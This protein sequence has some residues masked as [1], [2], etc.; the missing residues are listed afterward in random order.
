MV[1][2]RRV[3]GAPSATCSQHSLREAVGICVVC[4]NAM[5][6]DCITKFDG[7]NH[8]RA[9]IERIVKSAAVVKVPDRERIPGWVLGGVA[10]GLLTVLSYF[11]LEALLPG[12]GTP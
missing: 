8:C 3:N 7:I 10:V 2:S 9:C 5:C 1:C 6:S 4:K 11:M 12:S